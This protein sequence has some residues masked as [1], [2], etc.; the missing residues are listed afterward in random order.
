MDNLA[1]VS[2]DVKSGNPARLVYYG[3][4]YPESIRFFNPGKDLPAEP[5]PEGVLRGLAE[6]STEEWLRQYQGSPLKRRFVDQRAGQGMVRGTATPESPHAPSALSQAIVLIRRAFALKARDIWNSSILLAQAPIIA[7][8]L[9]LIF[10]G[11]TRADADPASL[12]QSGVA[13]A[14]V[15]FLMNIAAIWFGCSNAAREIVAEWTVF[16]RERM[17]GL[18]L[19]AY[20][21]SKVGLLSF[22]G[23]AQC[24]LLIAIVKRGCR[25]DGPWPRLLLGLFL[26]ALVGSSLGLLISALA[27]SSEVAISLVP[28]AILPMVVLGGMMQPVHEMDQPART[29]AQLVPSRWAFELAVATEAEFRKAGTFDLAAPYFPANRRSQTS[30]TFTVLIAQTCL[31]LTGT[32][33]ILRSRDIH[34]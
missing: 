16:S 7:L 9:V 23:L 5:A 30:T 17:V 21:A 24:S 31:F 11:A 15:L 10:G 22:I 32:L 6:R 3:P 19:A 18:R 8:L 33:S 26:S 1:V 13:R 14:T 4:A 20:L 25:I 12:Q 29:L 2:R 34:L 28:L 27:R